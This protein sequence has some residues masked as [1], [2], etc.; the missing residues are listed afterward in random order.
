MRARGLLI[1]QAAWASDLFPA[2]F[3]GEAATGLQWAAINLSDFHQSSYG[4]GR[5]GCE[6]RSA[7]SRVTNALVVMSAVLAEILDAF[8][9]KPRR[10]LSP[11]V[12]TVTITQP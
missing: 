4:T 12:S 8:Y 9:I 7:A 6:M 2:G 3:R 1:G 11:V 10:P 5:D